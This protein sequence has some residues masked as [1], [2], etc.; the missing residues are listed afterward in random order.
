MFL[1]DIRMNREPGV[2]GWLKI[3]GRRNVE[4]GVDWG[5][6]NKRII[7]M[8]ELCVNGSICFK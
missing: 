4:G 7:K 1:L 2:C 5:V 3:E 8:Y 6:E